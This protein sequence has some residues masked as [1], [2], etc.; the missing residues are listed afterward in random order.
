[1]TNPNAVTDRNI[2]GTIETNGLVNGTEYHAIER[3]TVDWTEKGLTITRLRLLTDSCVP[4]YDIS[5][6][7]GMLDGQPVRVELP[8]HQVPKKNM[9]AFLINEAK[10]AGVFAKG[11]GILDKANWSILV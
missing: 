3:E 6:C 2:Y 8:F 11:L 1:M 9:T 7:D 5:Y 4:F 10:K